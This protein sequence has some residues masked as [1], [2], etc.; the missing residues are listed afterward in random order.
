MG[1]KM[2]QLK[3]LYLLVVLGICAITDLKEK[4]IKNKWILTGFAG[5][6]VFLVLGE[7][8]HAVRDVLIVFLIFFGILFP[9]YFIKAVGAGDVKLICM[10]VI[11]IGQDGLWIFLI[12]M[13]CVSGIMGIG[14]MLHYGI[15]KKRMLYFITYMQRVLL[16]RT[17]EE[18]GFPRETE[19][20]MRM[21]PAVFWGAVIWSLWSLGL[22][23]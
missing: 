16:T 1:W 22:L 12:G 5:G 18:Y 11:Y 7:N 10:T 9:L 21:A 20:V 8:V 3:I 17:V 19:E 15:V 6:I 14:K 4:K 23:M 13:L 2:L